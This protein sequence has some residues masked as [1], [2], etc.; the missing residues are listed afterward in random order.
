MSRLDPPPS[1]LP[2]LSVKGNHLVQEGGTEPFIFHGV[3]RDTLEWGPNNW[4]GCGG[5]G[6]FTDKDFANIAAWGANTVRL[7]LSQANWLGRRC[8]AAEYARMVDDA[9]AK[10]NANGLYAILDLHWSD[11]GGDAP[12]DGQNGCRSGQQPM[13]DA[14]SLIFWG[15]VAA[16]YANNPGVMFNFYNEPYIYHDP[17]VYNGPDAESWRCWRNGGCTVYASEQTSPKGSTGAP[18]PVPYKAVGMQQLYDTVRQH[19][20]ESIVL[21][22]G[23]DWASDLSG[24]G[25]GYGLS[26]TNI[27]YDIHVYTQ[28][29]NTIADWDRHFGFLTKTHPVSS[30]EFG[31]IDCTADVTKKLIDYFD[32]PMGDSARRISWTIWSWNS[33]GE[34][35]QPS[36]IADWNGT[37]LPDQGTVVYDK[38]KAYPK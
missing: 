7:P 19:A 38:M 27:V 28:W 9:V 4:G 1:S 32:A 36:I 33:P 2:K 5:D 25:K 16:R 30:T 24:I 11:V 8:D 35:S 21:V 6:H 14:D 23:L 15:V 17:F 31:S 37:P 20:P 10:A 13:P 26:G 29:H 3:N 22:G 18:V 12:C 34:C